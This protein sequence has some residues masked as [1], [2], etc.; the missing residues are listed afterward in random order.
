[1]S[2]DL[3][4]ASGARLGFDREH[5]RGADPAATFIV[6]HPKKLDPTRSRPGPAMNPGVQLARVVA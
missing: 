3:A 5:Q 2:A 4:T 6:S 1:M